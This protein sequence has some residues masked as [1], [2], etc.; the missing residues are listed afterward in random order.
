LN[1]SVLMFRESKDNQSES[2]KESF[3]LLSIQDESTIIKL[4]NESIKFRIISLKSYYQ[5]DDH[6]DNNDELS[7]SMPQSIESLTESSIESSIKSLVESIAESQSNL[8]HTDLTTISIVLIESIKRERDRSRKYFSSIAY[9][10]FIFNTT[11]EISPVS[12]FIASRQ[13]EIIELLKKDV[14][15]L[16]NKKNVPT[17]VRIFSSRF[18][19]EIKHSEIEKAFEKFRLVIQTFNNQNKTLILTQS[20]IIQR[21][22]QRLIIC[23]VVSLSQMKLYLRDIIQAYVQSRSNLNRDFYVQSSSELIKLMRISS[24]CI[25]KV[26]KSL[27]EVSETNNHWFKT[28]HDHHTD[29][30]EMIQFT[31]DSCLLYINHICTRIVSMQ[32]D[33]T[34][35]L[36]D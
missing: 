20:S 19:N 35:I 27:Y 4:S 18:V 7:S 30:L 6:A 15:I 23:L 26:I 13:K 34:L 8:D 29:K 33:D 25:L 12:S 21:I 9:L 5:N 36:A 32:T 1:S 14:F 22:N 24:E 11:V 16:I 10:S 17:D 2:W 31:Y 28:Y 3:K